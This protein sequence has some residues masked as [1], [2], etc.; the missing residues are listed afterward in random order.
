MVQGIKHLQV[1]IEKDSKS[2]SLRNAEVSFG[3]TKKR[4]E[5]KDP[6]EVTGRQATP[7]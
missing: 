3:T 4:T 7:R 5:I 1:K 2:L 6:L